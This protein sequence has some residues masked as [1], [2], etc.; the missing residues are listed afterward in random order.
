MKNKSASSLVVSLGKTPN[1]MPPS[2]CGRQ[3]AQPSSLPVIV[4]QFIRKLPK[5]VNEKLIILEASLKKLT[6]SPRR[7]Y[8]KKVFTSVLSHIVWFALLKYSC[9]SSFEQFVMCPMQ[10][11]VYINY[12]ALAL[13]LSLQVFSCTGATTTVRLLGH[14]TCL[15]HKDKGIPLSVLPK[16]TTSKLAGLFSTLSLFC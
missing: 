10:E 2:L 6:F 4:A 9:S 3:V 13:T 8:Q 5:R 12:T 14:T 16:N 7:R 1:R 11:D 15:P